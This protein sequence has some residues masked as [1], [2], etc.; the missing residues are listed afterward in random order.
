MHNL[1]HG[2]DSHSARDH[3]IP[4]RVILDFEDREMHRKMLGLA[5]LKVAGCT[6]TI[7]LVEAPHYL[8]E[9]KLICLSIWGAAFLF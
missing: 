3:A 4:L 1:Y 9:T 8:V 5:L 6:L 7:H 2:V